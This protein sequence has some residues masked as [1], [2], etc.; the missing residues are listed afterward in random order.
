MKIYKTKKSATIIIFIFLTLILVSAA[1][2]QSGKKPDK[3]EKGTEQQ[4]K[5]T[6]L[7]IIRNSGVGI[8]ALKECRNYIKNREV[9]VKLRV[10]FLSSGKTTNIQVYEDSGCE[11]FNNEAIKAAEKIKFEPAIKDGE[12]ITI[13]KIVAYQVGIR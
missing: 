6:P 7:K 8:D 12:S 9:S 10:T 11:Y 4:Q 3:S 1:N 13:T 5:D 2:A